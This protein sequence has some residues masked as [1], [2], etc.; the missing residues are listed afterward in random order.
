MLSN[1]ELRQRHV[2]RCST[3]DNETSPL[4]SSGDNDKKDDELY[5]TY[6]FLGLIILITG[7]VC[8]VGMFG[9]FLPPSKPIDAVVAEF[10]G[11][12]ARIHM[13]SI[14]SIGPRPSGS[15]ANDI[16]AVKY[17]LNEVNRIREEAEPHYDIEIELQTV[18]GSFAFVRKSNYID[19]GF[20]SA[21]GNISNVIVKISPKGD[22]SSG[23]YLL[24]NAHY[25]TVMNTEG[26]SDDTVS[27][28]VLIEAFR[29]LSQTYD[30]KI[31]H[32]VIF[33]FNGAEEG[34]LS[35]GHAFI[36]HRWFPLVKAV[37]NVEAAG[38]G[39]NKLAI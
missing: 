11:D 25:D 19:L 27:C 36:Q 39:M 24:A 26:A 18:S 17:I 20:T 2:S 7:L 16:E 15:Y 12:R 32:G 9:T 5:N 22:S 13:E 34:G 6:H 38:S 14:A 1:S 3:E 33:L 23:I 8:T 30:E 10:S 31:R 21:Y 29:T 35:G 28:A 37:V 4:H